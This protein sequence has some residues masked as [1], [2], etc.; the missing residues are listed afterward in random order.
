MC[1]RLSLSARCEAVEQPQFGL[2]RSLDQRRL[3][4]VQDLLEFFEAAPAFRAGPTM[5]SPSASPSRKADSSTR[6]SNPLMIRT[7]APII[8]LG[9]EAQQL[10]AVHP[11]HAEIERDH[12]R[13]LGEEGVAEFLVVATVMIGS[14]PHSRA[15]LARK[16][17]SAGSSSISS[18]RG[19]A[20][21]APSLLSTPSV[22]SNQRVKVKRMKRLFNRTVHKVPLWRDF[23]L[24]EDVPHVRIAD[25]AERP[26]ASP[27]A[28]TTLRSNRPLSRCLRRCRGR[29]NAATTSALSADAARR[30]ADRRCR[31]SSS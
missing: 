15:A 7:G 14:N 30:Q 25:P 23:A 31:A 6:R 26:V 21:Q 13:A 16:S 1:S 10:D 11:G 22:R 3:E 8:L 18:S 12:V 29:P 9:E 19:C 20:I 17:A 27:R 24:M 4:L 28:A 5:L 2:R